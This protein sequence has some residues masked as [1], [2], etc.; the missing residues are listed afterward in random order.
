MK[1]TVDLYFTPEAMCEPCFR[2]TEGGP[3]LMAAMR[4]SVKRRQLIVLLTYYIH[5]IWAIKIFLDS[6]FQSFHVIITIYFFT[7]SSTPLKPSL[8]C[9]HY[10]DVFQ[11][12]A[13][14]CT[15]TKVKFMYKCTETHV[16][17]QVCI[18]VRVVGT[19]YK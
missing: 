3:Q 2:R 13:Q 18:C 11:Q 19:V 4:G 10:N 8:F 14:K 1:F 6:K 9:I 15:F 7:T 12:Q 16:G 5:S 17:I